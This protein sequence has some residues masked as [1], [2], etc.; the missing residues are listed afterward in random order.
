MILASLDGNS[1]VWWTAQVWGS[2]FALYASADAGWRTSV[3]LCGA[4]IAEETFKMPRFV[5]ETEAYHIRGNFSMD[6][7]SF[8]PMHK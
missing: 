2:G 8:P 6:S 1:P 7:P 4:G 5:R 3:H